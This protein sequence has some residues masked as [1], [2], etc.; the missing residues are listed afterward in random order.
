MEGGEKRRSRV[1]EKVRKNEIES[2]RGR[3]FSLIDIY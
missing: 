1:F 2:I 3:V